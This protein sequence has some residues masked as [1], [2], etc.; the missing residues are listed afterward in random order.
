MEDI[1]RAETMPTT[2]LR[3]EALSIVNLVDV[4]RRQRHPWMVEGFHQFQMAHDIVVHLL[5]DLI[6][7]LETK[8]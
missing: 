3:P 4:M 2:T 6:T 1:S 8:S 7:D 5:E